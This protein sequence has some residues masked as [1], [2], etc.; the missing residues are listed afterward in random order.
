M[1]DGDMEPPGLRDL[2]PYPSPQVERGEDLSPDLTLPSPKGE[3]EREVRSYPMQELRVELGD[4]ELPYKIRGYAAVFDGLS[5]QLWGGFREKINTGAF[6]KTVKKD[7]IRALHNHDA[8]YVL[9]RTKSMTLNLSED[10]LGLKFAITPPDTQWARDLITTIQR[11]D[12]DQM[13]FAF[14]AEREN[15]G[16]DKNKNLIRTLEEVTL[17]DISVVTYPAYPQTTVAVRDRVARLK[18]LTPDP[19]PPPT[20][21]NPS[22]KGGEKG[23]GDGNVGRQVSAVAKG[24]QEVD[25][26]IEDRKRKIQLAEKAI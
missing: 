6:A 23:E 8:N 15:W 7:D 19:Q 12:V 24:D 2:T 1:E 16:F 22:L 14:Q 26:A 20:Y 17:Y 13:S 10:A 25:R 4:H 11:G 18:N 9:G 21:P 5:N 3:G